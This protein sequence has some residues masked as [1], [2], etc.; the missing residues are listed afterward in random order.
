MVY[1]D[2]KFDRFVTSRV[3]NLTHFRC[4]ILC[5]NICQS[6]IESFGNLPEISN[7]N[8]GTELLIKFSGMA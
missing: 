4:V 8:L 7:Y 3:I 1:L 2:Y 5:Y 6:M